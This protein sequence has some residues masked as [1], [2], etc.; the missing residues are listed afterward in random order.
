MVPMMLLKFDYKGSLCLRPSHISLLSLSDSLSLAVLVMNLV[1]PGCRSSP[2][3]DHRPL[4]AEAHA[5]TQH[6]VHTY[7]AL[8]RHIQR[9]KKPAAVHAGDVV[10]VK[11]VV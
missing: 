10:C 3:W 5:Q 2:L 1:L 6:S 7:V 9:E 11:C 8:C 4:C